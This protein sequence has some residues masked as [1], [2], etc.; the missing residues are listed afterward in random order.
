MNSN[1]PVYEDGPTVIDIDPVIVGKDWGPM[2]LTAT[3]P[4]NLTGRVY[5]GAV[6]DQAGIPVAALSVGII[7]AVNE[8]IEVSMTK[9]ET[10][11]LTPGSAYL[12][13]CSY[14]VDTEDR[15]AYS[16]TLIARRTA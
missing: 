5:S 8:V 16:G 3:P 15:M 2:R 4:D 1:R 6:L 14:T 12:W 13:T 9:A 7:D 10:A 11:K